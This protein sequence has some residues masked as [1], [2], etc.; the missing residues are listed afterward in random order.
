MSPVFLSH[1]NS[2]RDVSQLLSSFTDNYGIMAGWVL[3]VDETSRIRLAAEDIDGI[4]AHYQD[5]EVQHWTTARCPTTDVDAS[6]SRWWTG[7]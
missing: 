2:A 3:H 4:V 6:H 1:S 5:P 7:R